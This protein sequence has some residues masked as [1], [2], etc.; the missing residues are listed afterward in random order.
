ML[1]VEHQTR[2]SQLGL[3]QVT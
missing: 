1:F 3:W 2:H